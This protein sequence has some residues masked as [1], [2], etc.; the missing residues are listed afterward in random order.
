MIAVLSASGRCQCHMPVVCCSEFAQTTG[1]ETSRGMEGRR[2]CSGVWGSGERAGC[3][4]GESKTGGEQDQKSLAPPDPEPCIG[5]HSLT[6]S[7][8]ILCQLKSCG[9]IEWPHW[10]AT[11][12]T[13]EMGTK[14]PSPEETLAA[15]WGVLRCH[16]SCFWHCSSPAFWVVQDWA[17]RNRVVATCE[18]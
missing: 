12:L 13:W 4:E 9:R 8:P 7:A 11:F 6:W 1:G 18:K 16:G 17:V 15:V 14:Y 3:G 5:L 10:R 2:R